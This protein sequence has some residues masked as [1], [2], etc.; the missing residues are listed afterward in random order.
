MKILLTGL[1]KRKWKKNKMKYELSLK[2]EGDEVIKG[3]RINFI[4][5]NDIEVI[6]D[7]VSTK[8]DSSPKGES[9]VEENKKKPNSLKSKSVI[10]TSEE[11]KP[12]EEMDAV[13]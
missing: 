11:V 8:K 10:E 9:L 3:V 2:I 4:G 7:T 5:E 1:L 12:P 13:F 6:P